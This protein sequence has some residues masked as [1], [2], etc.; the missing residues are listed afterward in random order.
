MARSG[1]PDIYQGKRIDVRRIA[2]DIIRRTKLVKIIRI[3]YDGYKAKDLVNILSTAGASG[4]LIP[5]G[6]T[7]GNFNLP[8]ESFE[9][10]AYAEPAQIVF[11]NN[12]INVYCLT[13]CVIDEDRLENKKPLKISQYRKIDGTI[14][15]LMTLGQLYSY[16]R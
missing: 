9:M 8:V 15:M 2:D 1:P 16:E 14:T 4:V 3:G 7:Y 10:L 13:N 6:Q 12:P 11:N 5:Y